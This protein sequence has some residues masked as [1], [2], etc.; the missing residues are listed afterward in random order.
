MNFSES[1]PE[2]FVGPQYGVNASLPI[3]LL[4][5]ISGP[6][7]YILTRLDLDDMLNSSQRSVR[8]WSVVLHVAYSYI[9]GALRAR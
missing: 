6:N 8:P 9:L 5:I 4:N 3:V 1:I 2:L 7:N